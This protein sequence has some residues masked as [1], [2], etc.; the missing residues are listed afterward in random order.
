MD[1]ANTSCIDNCMHL[2]GILP[3]QPEPADRPEASTQ[4]VPAEVISEGS[5][6]KPAV[7]CDYGNVFAQ[8]EVAIP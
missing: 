7:C 4:S 2:T 5:H 6:T 1:T 8:M 3:V